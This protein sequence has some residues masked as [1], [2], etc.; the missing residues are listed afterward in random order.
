MARNEASLELEDRDGA[1]VLRLAGHLDVDSAGPIWDQVRRTVGTRPKRDLV[2]EASGLTYCDSAGIALLMDLEARAA[3]AQRRFELRDFPESFEPLLALSRPQ[4]LQRVLE[5]PARPPGFVERV[6][7]AVAGLAKDLYSL[8]AYFGELVLALLYAARHPLRVRWKDALRTAQAAGVAALP[9]VVLIGFLIGLVLGFQS[10]ITLKRFGADVFLA[11]LVGLSM[12]R[13]LG[14][15]MTAVVMTARSSSAFAAEL[16]T[17]EVNEE[18]DALTTMGLD[19]VRFLLVPRTVAVIAVAPLLT[20]FSMLAGL[21][22]GGLVSVFTLDLPLAIYTNQLSNV[23]ALKDLLGGLSKS[24][25]FGIIVVAV[26]CIRGLQTSGGA[27]GV[28]SSTTR[29]V[30]SAIVLIAICD[31]LFSFLFYTLG[32]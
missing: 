1:Q 15:L 26:G 9:V 32:I 12:V 13:E 8:I 22:G 17:M 18:I 16:G 21:C 24:F 2:V 29:A 14:P 19:P 10:A 25:V 11:N 28:G 7:A 27:V 31:S 6:G 5:P 3:R 23:L 20:A 30:V 4:D